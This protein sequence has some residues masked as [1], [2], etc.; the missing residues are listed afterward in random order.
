MRTASFALLFCLAGFIEHTSAAPFTRLVPR[1]AP[2]I[3]GAARDYPGGN[4]KVAHL[5]DGDPRTEYSSASLGP[6]TFVEFDFGEPVRLAAFRHLD[7]N[8]PATVAAS[9][10]HF[11]DAAGREV[12][13]AT[14]EHANARAGVTF[15][16]L[17]E[18][19]MTR[20]VRWQVS[21]LGPQG[22][23]TVGG[24]EIAFFAAGP[25]EPQPVGIEITTE[26]PALAERTDA[27]L[28]QPLRVRV[29]YPYA[30][31]IEVLVALGDAEPRP[32][33]LAAG[34]QTVEIPLPP[35]SAERRLRLSVTTTDGQPLRAQVVTVPPFRELTV[36]ILP[37]SH[38]DIGYTEIQTDIEEKQVNNLL[39]GMAAAGR[40]AEYPEGARFVWNV[41]VLWAADLFLRRLDAPQREAFFAAVRRG[42]VALNGMYLNELTGLCRPEELVRLFRFATEMRRATGVPLDAAMMSDVPGLTWGAVPAM[43]SAGI[44]YLSTAPNYFDR[45]GNIL[46]EW[47]NRPFWWVGPDGR[48]R[49]LVWI[50]FWGYAMSH[51]YGR[52]S[53][54][55]VED[56]L[57]GLAKRDY[58]YEIAYVRWAGH[59]DN[60]VPDPAICDFVRDWGARYA[61][62]RFIIGSTHEAFAAF[63][64]RH[65]TELPEVTGDWT[66]YWEDGAGSS[67]LE[68]ALNRASSERLT[69]AEAL[70]AMLAPERYPAPDFAEA[71]RN[72]LLYSEHTWG[73]WCSVSEPLRRETL[74]QWAIKHSYA[75]AADRQSRALIER[76]KSLSPGEV[77]VDAVDLYNTTSWPRTELVTIP[78]DFCEGRDRVT[79]DQGQPVASQRLA[80]GELVLLAREV[81]PFAARRYRFERGAPHVIGEARAAEL[82][83]E[84][85]SLR[86]ILDPQT[87][88]IAGLYRQGSEVNLVDASAGGQLNDYLY[89]IGDDPADARRNDPP[90]IQLKERGPLVVSLLVRSTAP[91]CHRLEREVR[92]VAGLDEVALFNLVDKARLVADSYHA[93]EGKESVNFAFPFNVP[94]GRI[95]IEVPFGVV[96]PDLDQIPSACKNW[97]TAGRWADVANDDYG[98]TWVT[99]DAPLVEVG[100]LSATLLNSQTDPD[101]WRRYVGP[102]QRLFSW[103]MNNHWGTNYR[104][105]QEGPVMFRY[106]LRPH[107]G[108]D[109][110]AASRLAIATTQPLIPIRARGPRPDPRPRLTVEDPAVLVCGLKPADDGQGL[111]VR[112]WGAAGRDAAV[113]LNWR[114]PAPVRSWLS[115]TGEGRGS[116]VQGDVEVPGWGLVTLRAEPGR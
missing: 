11:L 102:T 46:V 91:G 27:G 116:E 101:V 86:V 56:F 94:G 48:S 84:N 67:A 103:A 32:L 41:E 75:A 43:N 57:T 7:R 110:A 69:Q 97:F 25:L 36:Y 96:R 35:A 99:L 26:A 93:T 3:A 50:P 49:V 37:H 59:G 81:P 31:P 30:E 65:G 95:R 42:E 23:G 72:V 111:V 64:R 18:P 76:A 21:R 38:T 45:I 14:V 28:R 47:E 83:I 55:L 106:V 85:A 109:P 115:D 22:Y 54:T 44:R 70:W 58:P 8:D 78:R 10:L 16:V 66:P 82:E 74:E 98:L 104:A 60:G 79:D 90:T 34:R 53:P 80:S 51:R 73:A 92:L 9:V 24:A 33:R 112:L 100:E 113:S 105:C 39:A 15:H 107:S 19:V 63:E 114:A 71:W 62:P 87:G 89:L 13:R 52:L 77:V 88:A 4:H 2:E 5:V 1:P 17:P 12:G 68:T 20:R 40:T 61:W 29:D 6:D 108:Y